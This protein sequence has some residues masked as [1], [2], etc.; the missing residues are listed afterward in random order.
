MLTMGLHAIGYWNSLAWNCK[1][2][3]NQSTALQRRGTFKGF[4][5]Q[6][7]S[8]AFSGYSN[9]LSFILPL[10]PDHSL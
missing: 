1:W 3:G 5:L 2:D 10:G 6:K 7:L 9:I 8:A 4:P